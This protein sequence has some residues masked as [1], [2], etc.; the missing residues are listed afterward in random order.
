M[1]CNLDRFVRFYWKKTQKSHCGILQGSGQLRRKARL[2]AVT[3][4]VRAICGVRSG[5]SC[6]LHS[7]PLFLFCHKRVD[8]IRLLLMRSPCC[9]LL[10]E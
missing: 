3:D 10:P 5:D 1:S 7:C 4:T 9:I 2:E 8:F 6:V